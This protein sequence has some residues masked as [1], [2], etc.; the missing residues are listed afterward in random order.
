MSITHEELPKRKMTWLSGCGV[1]LLAMALTVFANTGAATEAAVITEIDTGEYQDVE[2]MGSADGMIRPSSPGV[3]VTNPSLLGDLQG[4]MFRAQATWVYP[5]YLSSHHTWGSEGKGLGTTSLGASFPVNPYIGF[6]ALVQ[7]TAEFRTNTFYED[8]Y[9]LGFGVTFPFWDRTISIGASSDWH[10]FTGGPIDY[11]YAYLRV[12][13]LLNLQDH[14]RVGVTHRLELMNELEELR[15]KPEAPCIGLEFTPYNSERFGLSLHGLM[16]PDWVGG[17][18]E[19]AWIDPEASIPRFQEEFTPSGGISLRFGRFIELAGRVGKSP[20]C[21]TELAYTMSVSLLPSFGPLRIGL[22]YFSDYETGSSPGELLELQK[23]G[24]SLQYTGGGSAPPR[25]RVKKHFNELVDQRDYDQGFE[26]V[27]SRKEEISSEEYKTMLRILLVLDLEKNGYCRL[28]AELSKELYPYVDDYPVIHGMLSLG[29]RCSR[30]L[31]IARG[32]W[33]G[34]RTNL[35]LTLAE[36]PYVIDKDV[37]IRKLCTMEPGVV[38]KFM[39]GA[40]MVFVTGAKLEARGGVDD[41]I[42]LTSIFEDLM[43]DSNNDG[44]NSEPQPRDWAGIQL[45]KN[46]LSGWS[47]ES[48]EVR[49]SDTEVDVK[50]QLEGM[51]VVFRGEL[52]EKYLLLLEKLNAVDSQAERIK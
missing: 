34:M 28:A 4:F 38:V 26:F 5:G 19:D 3:V 50:R 49:Y 43:V 20:Y 33:D 48:L 10:R 51:G 7:R 40:K 44:S 37:T 47:C 13:I 22:G 46:D 16:Q 24:V 39:P 9:S 41:P 18:D 35:H 23:Y 21:K 15:P 45:R 2:S 36:S 42:I 14:V 32:E 17:R 27:E 8:L 25:E 52:P 29:D 31:P 11:Q 30:G 1:G 6:G 12:G